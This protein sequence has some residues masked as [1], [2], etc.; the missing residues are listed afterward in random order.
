MPLI[1]PLHL[2][3]LGQKYPLGRYQIGTMIQY[4]TGA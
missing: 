4:I 1:G 2:P 3:Y